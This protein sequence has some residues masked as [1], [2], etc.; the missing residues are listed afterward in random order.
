MSAA[1]ISALD[2]RAWICHSAL[3]VL[4]GEQKVEIDHGNRRTLMEY[5][6][7]AGQLTGVRNTPAFSPV[8]LRDFLAFSV[9]FLKATPLHIL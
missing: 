1:K 2:L 5:G 8:G 7:E 3:P 9:G 4:L 6:L